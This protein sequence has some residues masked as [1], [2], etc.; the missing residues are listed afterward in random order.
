MHSG[1]AQLPLASDVN[2]EAIASMT[3]GFSGADLQALLSDAQLASVHELLDSN[4]AEKTNQMPVIGDEL[5]RNVA[6]RARPS[7]SEAEKQRLDSIYSNFLDSKKS[8]TAQVRCPSSFLILSPAIISIMQM[9][10]TV[11]KPKRGDW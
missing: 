10:I 6:S 9:P 5:L 3:E 1:L 2:L 11:V 4:D 8:V 7:I